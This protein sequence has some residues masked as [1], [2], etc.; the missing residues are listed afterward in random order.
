MDSLWISGC[1]FPW[2]KWNSQ[3]SWVW[4]DDSLADLEGWGY[5]SGTLA[6]QGTWL[7]SLLPL[8]QR[9]L[10]QESETTQTFLW[11]WAQPPLKYWPESL[12]QKLS[13]HSI[14]LSHFLTKAKEQK[15]CK[16]VILLSLNWVLIDFLSHF[17]FCM[18]MSVCTW[19][20]QRVLLPFPVTCSLWGRGL[21]G[22]W[23]LSFCTVEHNQG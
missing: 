8:S 17:C 7:G 3:D 21:T 23:G 16:I 13:H 20:C 14:F 18:L 19:G 11:S 10:K 9:I 4:P 2:L 12:S 15:L 1:S 22:H 6:H 5:L